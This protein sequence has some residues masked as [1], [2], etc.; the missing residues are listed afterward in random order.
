MSAS[1]PAKSPGEKMMNV[2]RHRHN[3]NSKQEKENTSRSIAAS[4]SKPRGLRPQ[5]K[6]VK[7]VRGK[8]TPLAKREKKA[9]NN[10]ASA[11]MLRRRSGEAKSSDD[12]FEF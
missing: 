5:P 4:S 2:E 3:R 11:R 7:V 10:K 9:S 12:P 6:N 8:S 1:T